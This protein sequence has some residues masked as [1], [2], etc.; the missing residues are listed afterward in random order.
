M[1]L[2][3]DFISMLNH[4]NFADPNVSLVGASF[5]QITGYNGNPRIIQLAV[6]VF[7]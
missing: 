2:R 7:F 4:P 5:G 1:Q 6:K 3:G